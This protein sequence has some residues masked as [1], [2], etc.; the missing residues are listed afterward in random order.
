MNTMQAANP[1]QT[2]PWFPVVN[3]PPEVAAMLAVHKTPAQRID[4]EV[5]ESLLADKIRSQVAAYATLREAAADAAATVRN[6]QFVQTDSAESLAQSLVG[7]P[8]MQDRLATIDWVASPETT[9][10]QEQARATLD[11]QTLAAML[12]PLATTTA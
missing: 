12:A 4:P 1:H 2:V 6:P 10:P 8:E 3:A 11:E 5:H 7:L 9:M